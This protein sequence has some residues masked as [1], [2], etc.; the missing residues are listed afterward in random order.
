MTPLEFV[1]R[2]NRVRARE[3]LS[4]GPESPREPQCGTL[5]T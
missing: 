5:E 1:G 3:S 4:N 2:S